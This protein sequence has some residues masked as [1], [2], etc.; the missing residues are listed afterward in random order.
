MNLVIKACSKIIKWPTV[1]FISNGP[2]RYCRNG[3]HLTGAAAEYFVS[4]KV[5]S[6]GIDFPNVEK[7]VAKDLAHRALLHRGHLLRDISEQVYQTVSGRRF[8][9]I[10]SF[11][12]STQP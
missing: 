6:A 11:I 4:K 10:A 12:S 9:P 2:K 5:R 8:L 1:L 3:T 7:F